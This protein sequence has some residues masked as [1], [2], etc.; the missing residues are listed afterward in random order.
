ME[1]FDSPGLQ[2][3]QDPAE[4]EQ[5]NTYFET[6]CMNKELVK[7]DG[8]KLLNSGN[9]NVERHLRLNLDRNQFKKFD[10]ISINQFLSLFNVHGVKQGKLLDRYYDTVVSMAAPPPQRRRPQPS[11]RGRNSQ[12]LRKD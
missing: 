6:N 1:S 9:V 11:T 10:R 2:T 12:Q 8:F 4:P 5:Q 3:I 7:S